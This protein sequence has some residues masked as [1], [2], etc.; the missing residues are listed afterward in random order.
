M[1]NLSFRKIDRET[2]ETTP[3]GDVTRVETVYEYGAEVDG[4]FVRIGTFTEGQVAD[5]RVRHEVEQER[6]PQQDT[7]AQQET[8]SAAGGGNV[9][10]DEQNTVTGSRASGA[11][12]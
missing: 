11:K 2:G 5:A 9:V 8:S 10:P 1:A 3:T 6:N 7:P 12:K 4:V